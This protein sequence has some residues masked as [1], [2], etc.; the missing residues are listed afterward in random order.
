MR[1]RPHQINIRVSDDELTTITDMSFDL[2]LGKAQF[3]RL[4]VRQYANRSKLMNSMG[5]NR[6]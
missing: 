5:R 1:H 2:S 4:L 3:I 6:A